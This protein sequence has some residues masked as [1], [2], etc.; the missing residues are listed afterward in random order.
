MSRGP[1]PGGA[2]NLASGHEIPVPSADW[3]DLCA[4]LRQSPAG[5][6]RTTRVLAIV[7]DPQFHPESL[8][9]V[10]RRSG[11]PPTPASRRSRAVA[12]P[13][14][15]GQASGRFHHQLLVIL[16]PRSRCLPR[17]CFEGSPI[18]DDDFR[19]DTCK[20]DMSYPGRDR[21]RGSS[22]AESFR[23]P[24]GR[25][26][27]T[28]RHADQSSQGLGGPRRDGSVRGWFASRHGNPFIRGM[29][30]SRSN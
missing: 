1:C 7:S 15:R 4:P 29:R 18:F 8:R 26:N 25:V 24:K 10:N 13:A 12:H 16:A 2:R 22:G 19:V 6:V 21:R 3:P 14:F 17:G 20:D 23:G 30:R 11:S 9:R 27:E 28:K 5:A